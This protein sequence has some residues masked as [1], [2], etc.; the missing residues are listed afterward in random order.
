MLAN[1]DAL[2]QT[3][4]YRYNQGG[5]KE[6]QIDALN[7]VAKLGY[8]DEGRPNLR[9]LPLGQRLTSDYD[10]KG[11]Q[12]ATTDA[13]GQYTTY[14]YD[15]NDQLVQTNVYNQGWDLRD[16]DPQGRLIKTEQRPANSSLPS[17]ISRYRYD[18]AD[19][20]IEA[21]K[22]NGDRLNY[23]YDLNGNQTQLSVTPLNQATQITTTAY[24]ALG[25]PIQISEAS[26]TTRIGYDAVGHKASEVR[27]SGVTT[28]Y[29]YD[30][31]HRLT[32]IRHSK[33]DLL[34]AQYRYTLDATGQR[35]G[36]EETD[37]QGQI[38]VT[39]WDYDDAG[40]LIQDIASSGITT[41]ALDAVG[42]VIG[43]MANGQ[44][45][46][47]GYNIQGIRSSKACN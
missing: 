39:T 6:Q 31:R 47:F 35:L 27:P 41:Y 17:S 20:L 29:G 38:K 16:Y 26:G 9:T 43:K 34:L 14:L 2:G 28:T 42:H 37:A 21:L 33:G 1:T 8:T 4:Q 36:L 10:L 18:H 30:V 19:R 23:Q 40:R 12:S 11:R 24:D 25:R 45:I 13:R 3:T 15:A 44:G 5:Y 7:R 32:F 22:P 46:S